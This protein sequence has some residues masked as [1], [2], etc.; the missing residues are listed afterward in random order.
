MKVDLSESGL[1]AMSPQEVRRLRN[2]LDFATSTPGLV[3]Q[4]GTL[5]LTQE[6]GYTIYMLSKQGN[7]VLKELY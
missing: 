3:P 2:F 7:F 5:E 4:I 1:A 6:N